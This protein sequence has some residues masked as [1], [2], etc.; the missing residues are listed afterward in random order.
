MRSTEEKRLQL[1]SFIAMCTTSNGE[2][3]DSILTYQDISKVISERYPT[4]NVEII[5]VFFRTK[6][7]TRKG[8]Y[9]KIFADIKKVERI[10]KWRQERSLTD[11]INSL[12]SWYTKHPKGWK[13]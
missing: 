3:P 10:L 8:E 7:K 1:N 4:Q 13:S 6:G 11:S 9:A 2:S 12:V 5:K